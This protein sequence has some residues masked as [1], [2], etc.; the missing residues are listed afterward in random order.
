[1][2]IPLAPDE[3][4]RTSKDWHVKPYF[5][6]P[7]SRQERDELLLRVESVLFLE[8]LFGKGGFDSFF[9]GM[10]DIN[11]RDSLLFINLLLERKDEHH[12][13]DCFLYCSKPSLSPGPDSGAYV[14]ED[15]NREAFELFSQTEVKVR[16]IDEDSGRRLSKPYLSFYSIENFLDARKMG[17]NLEDSN[18]GQLFNRKNKL[19]SLCGHLLSA[20]SKKGVRGV[21]L[22]KLPDKRS[23]VLFS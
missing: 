11:R 2:S 18:N 9:E 3:L 21:E 7:A 16:R 22:S 19:H 15:R 10:A 13:A 8:F 1:M 4:N 17:D 23:P 20:D 5:A 12:A 6:F 14:I